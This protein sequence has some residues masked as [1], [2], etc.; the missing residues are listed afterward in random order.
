MSTRAKVDLSGPRWEDEK[1]RAEQ[2]SE[3]RRLDLAS[4]VRVAQ[5]EPELTAERLRFLRVVGEQGGVPADQVAE[6]LEMYVSD[7]LQSALEL[8][9]AGWLGTEELIPGRYPWTWLRQPGLRKAEIDVEG[10]RP[11]PAE[12]LYLWAANAARIYFAEAF[13]EARWVCYELLRRDFRAT[14]AQFVP[15]GLVEIE[16]AEGVIQRRAVEVRWAKKAATSEPNLKY[17]EAVLREHVAGY[18]AVDYF[19]PQHV[20]RL[21][22]EAG[23]DTR[24]ETLTIYELGE[25]AAPPQEEEGSLLPQLATHVSTGVGARLI[26]PRGGYRQRAVLVKEPEV[27]YEIELAELPV[28]ALHA[29]AEAV[30][31]SQL[32]EPSAAWKKRTPGH[33]LYCVV[34]DVGTFRV[35]RSGWGWRADKVVDDAVFDKRGPLV[36]PPPRKIVSR[37]EKE[38]SDELWAK[39]KPLLPEQVRHWEKQ[40][41]ARTAVAGIVCMLRNDMTSWNEIT[42]DLGF[43]TGSRVR[44]S[45]RK[46][47]AE[48]RWDAVEE[49]LK[50]E[51]E[52]A[53]D[54]DWP[55]LKLSKGKKREVT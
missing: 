10:G 17:I 36:P 34:T 20:Y 46:W 54:F 27:V 8:K 44:R 1:R 14:R 51:L 55:R 37:G 13:P 15:A 33:Q 23:L 18:E 24:F 43:G 41:P 16:D 9:R 50:E 39:I 12:A 7:V 35:A 22:D 19:C 25:P 21:V 2:I 32:P 29:I 26:R 3:R 38:I 31:S 42:A 49:I 11:E 47:E 28:N 6:L 4:T 30:G 52:D 40:Y 53:S 45:L 5:A 48:G